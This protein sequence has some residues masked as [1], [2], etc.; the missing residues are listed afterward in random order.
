MLIF[1]AAV[2]FALLLVCLVTGTKVY[3]ALLGGFLL[4]WLTGRRKGFTRAALWSMAWKELKK[5]LIVVVVVFLI[6]IITGLWRVSGTI[7]YC[8]VAGMELIPEN[9]FW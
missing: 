5:G 7:A 3:W 2:F 8:I 9:L 4:F 6:G 1:S